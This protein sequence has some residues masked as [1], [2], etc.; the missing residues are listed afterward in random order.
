[1]KNFTLQKYQLELGSNVWRSYQIVRRTIRNRILW[2]ANTRVVILDTFF[3]DWDCLDLDQIKKLNI[4]GFE[5]LSTAV[6]E[7]NYSARRL[8]GSRIIE[9]AAYCNHKLLSHLYVN[10]KQHLG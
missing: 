1:M 6:Q 2:L 9:S 4:Y 5:S 3:K 8:I 10:K 7:N